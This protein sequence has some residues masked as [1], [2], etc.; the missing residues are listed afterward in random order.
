[1][2][3]NPQVPSGPPVLQ[4]GFIRPGGA[5]VGLWP[6][7]LIYAC[8]VA[9]TGAT[10]L[11]RLGMGVSPGERVLLIIFIIPIILSAY[12]GG[13]GPG[14]LATLVA[15]ISVNYFLIP[16]TYT[17]SFTKRADFIQWLMLI[18]NGVCISGLSEA[19]HRSRRR[20]E[21]S[22]MLQAVTLASVGDGVIT[23]D[24]QELITFLN[25]EAER[26]T[27]WSR[28]EAAGQPLS[29]VFRVID[30]KTRQPYAAQAQ[31]LM[32]SGRSAGLGE[33]PVLLARDRQEFDIEA[34]AAPIKHEDGALGGMILVFHDCSEKRKAAAALKESEERYRRLV[35][36]S[37][38]AILVL[39]Q[40]R[41]LFVNQA[42]AGLLGAAAPG[43]LLGR[44]VLELIH[45]DERERAASR[46]ESIYQGGGTEPGLLT[47]L[48]LDGQ[49]VEVEIRSNRIE[50]QGQPAILVK[51]RDIT[52]RKRAEA[53]INRMASFPRLNPFP[54]LEVDA[55]GAIT[56]YNQGTM[57]ALE[58]LGPEY[59]PADFLPGDLGEIQAAARESGQDLFW[60]EV[61]IKDAVFSEAISYV[62]VFDVLRLYSIDITERQQ[63]EEARSRALADLQQANESLLTEIWERQAAEEAL[64]ISLRFLE[65][66]HQHTEIK[67]LLEAFV[68]ELKAY[69]GCEAVGIRVLHEAG[70]IPYLAYQGFSREF[71]EMEN[72]L[73][74][75]VDRCMCINVVKGTTDPK[76]PFYTPGGSFYMNGT[77]RFLA[78]VSAEEKGSTRNVCNQMGFESVA[79]IPL[80]WRDQILGLIHVADHQ[81]NM[82]PLKMVELL[83]KA[84][85]QLGTAINRIKAEEAL[86]ESEEHYRSLFDNMLNGYAFCRMIYE[87]GQ[88]VDFVYLEVNRAFE[89]LTGLQDVA[90]KKVSAVI[91]GIRESSPELFEIYG[92]VALTG[93]PERFE[94]YVAALKMWFSVSVYSTQKD[95]FVAVFDVITERKQ[96][97]EALRESETKFRGLFESMT[98]GVALHELIYNDRG[99]AVDYR[100]LSVNPAFEKHTGL[101]AAEV[102]GQT[103][104]V[105]YGTRAAP[106]LEIYAGVAHSG[107]PQTFEA[108]FPP[109]N[110]HFQVS[111]TS[112]KPG[113]FVTVFEDITTRKQMEEALTLSEAR[114]RRAEALG[115]LGHW[116]L[117]LQALPPRISGSEEMRRIFGIS[118]DQNDFT[119]R[120]L[121]LL[122]HPE[123]REYAG[124]VTTKILEEGQAAFRYRLQGQEGEVRYVDGTGEL[125]RNTAGENVAIFGTI[126]DTTELRQK[127]RELEE[128]TGEL[129]RFTYTISHDLRSPLVTI[130]TF[131]GYLDQDMTQ[132]DGERIEKDKFFLHTAAAKMEKLLDELL[133]MSRIGR[134]VNPPVKATFREVVEEALN[135]VAGAIATRGVEVHVSDRDCDLFGDRPR[136]VEIWQNLAENAAKF[137]GD[138]PSPLIEIGLEYKGPDTVFFV[139]D[140][141]QGIEARYQEKVFGLFEKL[142]PKTEG[143]GIGLALIKR[144]VEYYRGSIWLESPGP[145]QGTCFKFTL[146][147]AIKSSNQGE[148]P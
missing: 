29:A 82:V 116:S 105:A 1:M 124:Q 143:T 22:R 93:A 91:P 50:Y 49:P 94:L 54:V 111:A 95:H 80:V 76:L 142:D 92:R 126:L 102:E 135:A 35:E 45:Q 140:N 72:P 145:G 128:R 59:T 98:E 65:I 39:V 9:V 129:E 133:E 21:M 109:L 88:P 107:R 30:A 42:G 137:M 123:D 127:E 120:D 20:A 148:Q 46:L 24:I 28:Q 85:M 38:D 19:M 121:L 3:A 70:E 87:Q 14:L 122:I 112:P 10:L 63:A 134:I 60:R 12:A 83:E 108:F 106:Y 57:E 119:F 23:T 2:S 125:V 73:S 13:L 53:E 89:A 101:M 52:E 78:T 55:S 11:L 103:A 132:N 64:R 130:K 61:R 62:K 16:P 97:E 37:P 67:P 136:L 69:T 99:E 48:R 27:G 6:A 34:N 71:Y 81:E 84:G 44:E 68:A 5:A 118:A 104:S 32:A 79:L 144:I 31:E 51:A 8:A 146:P 74:I 75:E 141:G 41:L 18:V 117:D 17:L 36:M 114:L 66:A 100:I 40:G 33:N 47:L 7:W 96:A 86:R 113:Q 56:F 77:T 90:G 110:R 15:A 138:Q 26:L 43:E 25:P 115:H 58:K 147:G 131:L 4:Q 139:C